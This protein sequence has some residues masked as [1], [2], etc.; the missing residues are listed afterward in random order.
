MLYLAWYTSVL[1]GTSIISWVVFNFH[2]DKHYHGNN[3]LLLKFGYI[4]TTLMIFLMQLGIFWV[5]CLITFKNLAPN[6]QKYPL[7]LLGAKFQVSQFIKIYISQE[8]PI[9]NL[10]CPHIIILTPS[11]SPS[12]W[13]TKAKMTHGYKTPPPPQQTGWTRRHMTLVTLLVFLF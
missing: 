1:Q 2:L 13:Q 5:K 4:M 7:I 6:V 11:K 3:S 8:M 10:I 12:Q 9:Q